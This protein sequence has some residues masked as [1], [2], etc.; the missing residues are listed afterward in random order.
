M[1][2][3]GLAGSSVFSVF[4]LHAVFHSG[5]TNTHS[6]QQCREAPFSPHPCQH[7]LC[8]DFLLTAILTGVRW[9]LIVVL[10][11]FSLVISDVKHLFVCF[12]AT[13][14]SSLE[15]CLVGSSVRVLI[16]LFGY[17]PSSG[18]W[19]GHPQGSGW[20]KGGKGS[21]G[22]TKISTRAFPK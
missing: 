5:C 16:G 4:Y 22:S 20:G 14:M 11:C 21:G 8:V 10:I 13:C 2:R 1:P 9:Y 12:L 18:G 7:L 6:H 17:T 19:V 3:S 15:D